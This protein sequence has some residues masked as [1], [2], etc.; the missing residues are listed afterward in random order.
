MSNVVFLLHPSGQ[1][2]AVNAG[3]QAV[4]ILQGPSRWF[5]SMFLCI[6]LLLTTTVIS[7]HK[8]SLTQFQ[9]M[10]INYS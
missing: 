7:Q 2:L 1:T 10:R 3:S 9:T 6:Y 4:M 5:K 8:I